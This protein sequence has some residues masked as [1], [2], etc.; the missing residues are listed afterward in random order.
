[1]AHIT[2]PITSVLVVLSTR[3]K[4][5]IVLAIGICDLNGNLPHCSNAH[6]GKSRNPLQRV[7]THCNT[8]QTGYKNCRSSRVRAKALFAL[9]GLLQCHPAFQRVPTDSNTTNEDLHLNTKGI[10]NAYCELITLL[11]LPTLLKIC[12][13]H[14]F[15]KGGFRCGSGRMVVTN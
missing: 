3:T 13:S 5:Q 10:K 7:V 14:H 2:S 9:T 1:M 4:F 8:N 11:Q 6:V 12:K 15:T